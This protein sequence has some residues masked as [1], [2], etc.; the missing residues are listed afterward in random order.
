MLTITGNHNQY[1]CSP[2]QG[3]PITGLDG[4]THTAG[5]ARDY[6]RCSIPDTLF[7]S[8]IGTVIINNDDIINNLPRYGF[9]NAPYASF[10]VKR[11]NHHGNPLFI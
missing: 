2:L 10:F 4:C 8:R 5:S 1:A 6:V 7:Y 11:W 9:H 3:L